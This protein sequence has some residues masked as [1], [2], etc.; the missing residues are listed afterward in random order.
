MTVKSCFG[1]EADSLLP[2]IW[3]SKATLLQLALHD[4][5]AAFLVIRFLPPREWWQLRALSTEWRWL[6]DDGS[7]SNC[8][9]Y[10]SD[11]ESTDV[12]DSGDEMTEVSLPFE[13]KIGL[14][15]HL[16]EAM[17][18]LT[19]AHNEVDFA[20]IVYRAVHFGKPGPLRHLLRPLAD[21]SWA[22]RTFAVA[23]AREALVQAVVA[24]DV[25]SCRVVLQDYGPDSPA[26]IKRRALKREDLVLAMKVAA[27]WDEMSPGHV[28]PIGRKAVE[29][30]LQA[31]TAS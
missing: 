2:G 17:G 8:G 16:V 14:V 27:E 9:M 19:T 24:G 15:K 13:R 1:I 28:S 11:A 30:V 10:G 5:T 26:A 20:G 21:E 12:S 18:P 23:V 6:L 29:E 4:T 22:R 25:A 3:S 31:V 7:S